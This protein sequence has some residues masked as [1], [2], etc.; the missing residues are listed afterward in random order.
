MAVAGGPGRGAARRLRVTLVIMPG[1]RL[2]D[3][4]IVNLDRALRA[5]AGVSDAARRDYHAERIDEAPLAGSS[6][7]YTV[8]GGISQ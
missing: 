7:Q 8:E 1:M 6:T 3:T 5:V 4:V 2:A